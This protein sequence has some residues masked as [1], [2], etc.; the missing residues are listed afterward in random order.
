MVFDFFRL[1]WKEADIEESVRQRGR[2]L[3]KRKAI[4]GKGV[5]PLIALAS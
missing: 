2:V 1:T 3:S 5:E 4:Q